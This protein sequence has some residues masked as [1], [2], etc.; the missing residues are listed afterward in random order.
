[1]NSSIVLL[2]LTATLAFAQPRPDAFAQARELGRGVNLLGYD[3]VWQAREQGRFQPKHFR[4]IKEAGFTN[5]RINLFPF[6]EMSG[7]N[8]GALKPEWL[9]TLDWVV[10]LARAQNLKVIL[11]LHEFTV[12]GEAPAAHQQQFL[13]FW[14]QISAHCQKLPPEVLFEVLNEPFGKLTESLWNEYF[15]EALALIREKNPT[16]LVIVGPGHWNSF[17][18]L[19]ELVLPE[20]DRNLLVT[21]HY[22]QP[23]EFTHQG[24]PWVGRADQVGVSWEGTAAE[25]AAIKRDF[26]V[27]AA[28]AKQSN[29]PMLLGE[30]GAY[31][32]ADL[33]ARA[34]YVDAVARAAEAQGWSWAYWQ[35][36]R[37]FFVFDSARD[38]WVEPILHGLIPPPAKRD[39]ATP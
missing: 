39:G 31:E 3:R 21:I 19:G 23:F 35:F 9:D 32:K 6:R 38:R 34:R 7:A 17:A 10:G 16:R 8:G 12:M 26:D 33:A 27:A 25:R 5:V 30:F 15:A 2:L 4:L 14:R 37:D 1:M 13:A 18:H 28:W 11:D 29:R 24:A 22:Y 36:D 20:N